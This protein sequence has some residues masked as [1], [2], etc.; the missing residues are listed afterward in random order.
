MAILGALTLF[1]YFKS[2]YYVSGNLEN[3]HFSKKMEKESLES[4][5]FFFLFW[6][7]QSWEIIFQKP[8]FI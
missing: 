2:H 5:G 1:A 3:K 8:I 7:A 6:L 4:Q